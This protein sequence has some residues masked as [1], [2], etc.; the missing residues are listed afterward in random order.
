M[1]EIFEKGIIFLTWPREVQ[2]HGTNRKY[3]TVLVRDRE[4]NTEI[5]LKTGGRFKGHLNGRW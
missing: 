3:C 1:I 2:T 4:N 5:G